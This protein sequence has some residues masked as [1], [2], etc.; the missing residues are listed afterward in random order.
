LCEGKEPE[1]A[2]EG[3]TP[4]RDAKFAEVQVLQGDSGGG[5]LNNLERLLVD[6]NWC[7]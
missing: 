2:S 5:V 6:Q 4:Q 1:P 3:A 7:L